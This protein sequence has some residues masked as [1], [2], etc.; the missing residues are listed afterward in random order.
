MIVRDRTFPIRREA[1]KRK[2][3]QKTTKAKRK[4]RKINDIGENVFLFVKRSHARKI[5][6]ISDVRGFLANA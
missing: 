4:S 1:R 2:D 3:T 5:V 6:R